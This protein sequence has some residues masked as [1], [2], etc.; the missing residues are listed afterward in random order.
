MDS[1]ALLAYRSMSPEA[2]P[3]MTRVLEVASL[4]SEAASIALLKKL[5]PATTPPSW[6]TPLRLVAT[7]RREP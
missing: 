2:W 6:A 4:R 1:A 3:N 5:T 7:P